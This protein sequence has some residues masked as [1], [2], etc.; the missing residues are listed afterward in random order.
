VARV[1]VTRPEREARAWAQAL[2]ARGHAPL[3]LPLIEIGPAPDEAALQAAHERLAQFRA[4][5][6]VS[7]NAV[8][9]FFKPKVAASRIHIARAA[10]NLRAWAPGPGTA[11]ALRE[12]GWPADRIDAPPQD[13]AQ[14]DSESLWPQ[15]AAQVR[16]GDRVLVV[17]GANG[18]AAA[19]EAGGNGREWLADRIAQ[20]GGRVEAVAA[21]VR[22]IPQRTDEFAARARQAAADGSVWLFSS[23][24]AVRNLAALLPGQDWSA[25][26]AV[27]THE[28]IGEAA[29]SLGFGGVA[30]SRPALEAVVR[31]IESPQ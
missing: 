25:A 22:R 16:P 24:E 14:F 26:R 7:A 30:L 3:V 28:R 29:R 6:F 13:A 21:Y 17:R 15:V 19:P 1:V 23:S 8:D 20:A 2:A 12:A 5:M 27:A 9:A 11:Q 10:I 31:S 4:L 18:D